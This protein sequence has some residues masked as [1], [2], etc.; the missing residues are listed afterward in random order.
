MLR[1]LVGAIERR[2]VK[3]EVAG[4]RWMV[5]G[6]CGS[7]PETPTPE[8]KEAGAMIACGMAMVPPL[9]ERFLS[10]FAQR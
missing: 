3:Q 1:T 8:E 6:G 2:I 10:F 4:A 7:E 9:A 5:P